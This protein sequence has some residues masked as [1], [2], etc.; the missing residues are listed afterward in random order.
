LRRTLV[1]V[2]KLVGRPLPLSAWLAV[3]VLF[4]AAVL[5]VTALLGMLLGAAWQVTLSPALFGASAAITGLIG[6]GRDWPRCRTVCLRLVYPATLF[7][8]GLVIGGATVPTLVAIP[9]GLPAL[10]T[11]GY[12]CRQEQPSGLSR[13]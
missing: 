13:R 6:V 1:D 5:G 11:I 4:A 12:L 10:V 9:V 2:L 3:P 7:A 8:V